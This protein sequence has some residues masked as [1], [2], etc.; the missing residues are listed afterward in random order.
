MPITPECAGLTGFLPV[1]ESLPKKFLLF[2]RVT[3]LAETQWT[4][5]PMSQMFLLIHCQAKLMSAQSAPLLPVGYSQGYLHQWGTWSTS[6][7]HCPE[8]KNAVEET[9]TKINDR[10]GMNW[11][12]ILLDLLMLQ[13]LCKCKVY[14]LSLFNQLSNSSCKYSVDSFWRKRKRRKRR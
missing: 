9:S 6:G 5:W 4:L 2:C 11:I 14:F 12:Q 13:I 7:Y 1:M 3:Q 8:Q 10:R